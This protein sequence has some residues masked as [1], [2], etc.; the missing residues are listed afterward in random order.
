[1]GMWAGS[2]FIVQA[3]KPQGLTKLQGSQVWLP[4]SLML[5]TGSAMVGVGVL[6]AKAQEAIASRNSC[7]QEAT[8]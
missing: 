7:A 1:M 4:P 6:A 3:N 8:K 2:Q 5:I